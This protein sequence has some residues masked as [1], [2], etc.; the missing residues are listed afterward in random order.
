MAA[1]EARTCVAVAI[2]SSCS[3]A[4]APHALSLAWTVWMGATIEKP[5]S[6]TISSV[7]ASCSIHIILP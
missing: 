5:S 6:S 2:W 4:S 1:A 3:S 7:F